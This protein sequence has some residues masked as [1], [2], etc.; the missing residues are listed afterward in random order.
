M[1]SMDLTKE[2]PRSPYAKIN[3][4]GILARTIDKG[5]ATIAGTK[6]EYHFDCPLDNLLFS[7]TGIKAADMK[8]HL[9]EGK[10]DE[11]IGAWVKKASTIPHTDEEIKAWNESFH[12]DF[13]YSTDPQKSGWFKGECER[14]GLDADKTT[15]FTMLDADD[16]ASYSK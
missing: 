8:K 16:K 11:E 7:F 3:G 12:H 9:E 6:G 2:A 15:L 5:R 10:S 1:I 13:S 4:Y 14:L